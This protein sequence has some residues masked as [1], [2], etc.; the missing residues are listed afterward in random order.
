M[1]KHLPSSLCILGC[2]APVPPELAIEKLC[3]IH[4]TRSIEQRCAQMRLETITDKLTPEWQ[5]LIAQSLD[6]YSSRLASVS[7]GTQRLSDEMKKR[8]LATFLTLM[9]MREALYRSPESELAVYPAKSY[10]KRTA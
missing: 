5:S 9:I 1:D 2:L 10:I 8:I 4:F 6:A 7:T 3:I